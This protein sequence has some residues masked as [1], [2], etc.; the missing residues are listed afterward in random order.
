MWYGLGISPQ[1]DPD[2][3]S[4]ASELLQSTSRNLILITGGAYLAWQIAA[5]MH[6]PSGLGWTTAP[7]TL[8]V[9]TCALALWLLSRHLLAAQAMW[10]MGFAAAIALAMCV[11]QQPVIGFLYTLLPLMAVIAVGWL[12]GLLAEALVIVLVWG[13]SHSTAMPHLAPYSLGI[14]IGGALNGLLDLSQ[15]EAGPMALGKEWT[16]LQEIIDAAVLAVRALFES[17]KLY[18]WTEVPPDLPPVFCDST[19]I[20]QVVINLLSNA[21]RFTERGGSMD[22]G[23]V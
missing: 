1:A 23:M 14:V 3:A 21:G 17:K 15:V 4:T 6:Q 12:A 22:K 18:L 5:S 19:R 13:L 9:P 20:R 2:F 7:V 8:V 10:Q 16:S 11:F